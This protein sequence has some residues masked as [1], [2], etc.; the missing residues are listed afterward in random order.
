MPPDIWANFTQN[1]PQY[2]VEAFS[3]IDPWFY[4][5]VFLGII[6]F[7]YGATNSIIS[8]VIMIL[9]MFGLFAGTTSIFSGIPEITQFLYLIA[10]L[11]I[12]LLV[13]TFFLKRRN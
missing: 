4:P 5:L 6:G 3:A 13:V 2:I 7:V 10:I 9:I 8:A 12:T 11:G 1:P